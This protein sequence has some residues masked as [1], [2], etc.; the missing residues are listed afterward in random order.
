VKDDEEPMAKKTGTGSNPNSKKNLKPFKKGNKANPL[1]AK[2]HNVYSFKKL[3]REVVKDIVHMTT[4]GN[5]G[6]LQK[7]IH[8]KNSSALAVAFA[9]CMVR[10]INKGDIDGIET[11]IQRVVGKVKDEVDLNH[12]GLPQAPPAQVH[13]YLPANGRTKEE[14][15]K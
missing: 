4:S 15:Q 5:V 11:M 9:A 12:S 3:T 13:V 1:G 2:A 14:N 7:I 6:D 10:M 8:D